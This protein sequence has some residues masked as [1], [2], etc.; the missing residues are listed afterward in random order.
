M[1]CGSGISQPKWIGKGKGRGLA[2]NRREV[3]AV[4]AGVDDET[5]GGLDYG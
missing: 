5:D 3:S 4:M 2:Q 1:I